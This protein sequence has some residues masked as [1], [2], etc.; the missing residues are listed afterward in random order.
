MDNA[1]IFGMKIKLN[2]ASAV[3]H[4]NGGKPKVVDEIHF[5][6]RDVLVLKEVAFQ[7]PE[8]KTAK[9]GNPDTHALGSA[10]LSA[11]GTFIRASNENGPYDVEIGKDIAQLAKSHSGSIWFDSWYVSLV[12]LGNSELLFAHNHNKTARTA[13]NL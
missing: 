2:Q 7:F 9:T 6:N 4:L 3:L 11:E 10:I 5:V 1:Q 13:L 8:F 12:R